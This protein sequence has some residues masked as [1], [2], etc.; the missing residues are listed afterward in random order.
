[1]C[2]SWDWETREEQKRQEAAEAQRKRAG[3]VDRLLKDA[4]NSAQDARAER[5]KE[6]AKV[7][8]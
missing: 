5:A 2:H 7:K 4:K 3:I 6:P 8:F 1:M